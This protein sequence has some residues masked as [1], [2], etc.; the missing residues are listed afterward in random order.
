MIKN[1]AKF[2]E[3]LGISSELIQDYTGHVQLKSYYEVNRK[4][5][6]KALEG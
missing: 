5:I 3:D 2:F 1:T 6:F 4:R